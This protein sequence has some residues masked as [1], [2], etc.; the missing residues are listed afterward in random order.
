ME[1]LP[2]LPVG[3]YGDLVQVALTLAAVIVYAVT[4]R[5]SST[6]TTSHS[7]NEQ[8][9]DS[10]LGRFETLFDRIGRLERSLD[11]TKLDLAKAM[12]E[13]ESLRIE[14]AAKEEEIVALRTSYTVALAEREREIKSLKASLENHRKRIKELETRLEG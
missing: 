12:R 10:V 4:T 5:K 13:L 14:V 1:G 2:T 11:E 6:D 3:D 8:V 9:D 7:V